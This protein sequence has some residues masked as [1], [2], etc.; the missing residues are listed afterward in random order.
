MTR[1]AIYARYSSDNQKPTSI[2]DQVRICR[3]RAE[4]EGWTI[5]EVYKDYAISGTSTIN[6]TDF[7]RLVQDANNR[8]FSLIL[9]EALDRLSRDQEDIAGFYKRMQFMNVKIFTLQEGEITPLH[10]GMKGTMNALY[11]TDLAAKVRRGQRG[12]VEQGKI[13]GGNG[14]G[15]DVVKRFDEKG[16]PVRGERTI[17][18]D[19]AK[20]I[21]RIFDEYVAGKSPKAI[22]AQLNREG[23]AGPSGKGWSQSTI[24]GNWQRGSGLLN[25]EIYAGVIAWNKVRYVKNPDTGKNVTR[26]NPESEWIRKE[27][28]ELRI[29]DQGIWEKVKARQRRGRNQNSAFWEK[30]RPKY[31]FSRLLKCGVC[32]GGVCKISAHHYSCGAARSKG[33]AICTN[34]RVIRQDDLEHTVLEVLQHHLM[35]PNLV[36]AFCKE[37]T[38]HVNRLRMEH[39]ASL[40]A[41]RLELERIDRQERNIVEAVMNG[42]ATEAMKTQSHEMVARRKEL[43]D[44]LSTQDEAP[45]LLHPN[46]A[47]RYRKEVSTLVEAL[48]TKSHTHEAAELVRSLVDKIVLTP[49]PKNTGMLIDVYGD[50]AGILHMSVNKEGEKPQQELDLKQIRMVVGLD[51]L[52]TSWELAKL[53]PKNGERLNESEDENPKTRIANGDSGKLVGPE[54]HERCTYSGT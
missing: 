2:E 44:L 47:I 34:R 48:Q 46:M 14:Y 53:V 19:H 42:F 39:N 29:V 6:R 9:S 16:E 4:R 43:V 35:K 45:V 54:E 18:E 36:E 51:P 31:L 1:V 24:N 25:N 27:V 28:P 15:Y 17:N 41:Y 23:V 22:A 12:R 38:N 52:T 5:T 32:G 10:I 37:Y 11:I 40:H 33:T 49:N 13:G 7:K 8:E 3:E 30:Q 20:I 26:P 21:R 50:L